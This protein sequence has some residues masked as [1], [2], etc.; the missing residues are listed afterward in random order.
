MLQEPVIPQSRHD[1]TPWGFARASPGVAGDARRNNE[2]GASWSQKPWNGRMVELVFLETWP[3]YALGW[4][5]VMISWWILLACP[6]S[7]SMKQGCVW[8]MRPMIVSWRNQEVWYWP[9]SSFFLVI[10]LPTKKRK[11]SQLANAHRGACALQAFNCVQNVVT[12]LALSIPFDCTL[13][14]AYKLSRLLGE[15]AA[16]SFRAHFDGN[17]AAEV[18]LLYMTWLDYSFH[19]A[20][21]TY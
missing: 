9:S 21:Q 16:K 6:I 14:F 19:H 10:Y 2:L 17:A 18:Q 5:L 1:T 11:N 8:W 7:W 12:S 3:K 4:P 15:H 13:V 20:K